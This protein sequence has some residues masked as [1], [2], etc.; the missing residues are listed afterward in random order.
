LLNGN[1]DDKPELAIPLLLLQI[2]DF[3]V[4]PPMNDRTLTSAGSAAVKDDQAS[5][6]DVAVRRFAQKV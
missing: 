1:T 4:L 2:D 5:G 6:R 3:P